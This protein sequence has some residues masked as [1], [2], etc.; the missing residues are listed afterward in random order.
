MYFELTL[1][2]EG[3]EV[4]LDATNAA[5]FGGLLS[6]STVTQVACFHKA[7]GEEKLDRF[8]DNQL[9]ASLHGLAIPSIEELHTIESID[10]NAF[11]VGLRLIKR[12]F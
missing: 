5:L 4:V 1:P 6:L 11:A 3:V 2:C 10:G 7:S 12:L 8:I 9:G